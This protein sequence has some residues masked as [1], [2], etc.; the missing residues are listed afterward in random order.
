M[1]LSL[2]EKRLSIEVWGRQGILFFSSQPN[3]I[4]GVRVYRHQFY[5]ISLMFSPPLGGRLLKREAP[6]HR[7]LGSTGA[8]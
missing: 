3:M 7:D 2:S 5:Y 8:L 1:P 4:K 6:E